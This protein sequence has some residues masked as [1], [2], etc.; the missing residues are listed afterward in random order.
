[1]IWIGK[2]LFEEPPL[3]RSE[4]CRSGYFVP[5]LCPNGQP[6]RYCRQF[7]DRLL[8][9]DLFRRNLQAVLIG[10]R[11]YLNAYNGVATVFEEVIM[12]TDL[13][14]LQ[15]LRPYFDKHLFDWRSRFHVGPSR[16]VRDVGFGQRI[17]VNFTVGRQWQGVK[18]DKAR[19]DHVR[20]QLSAQEQ[21]EFLLRWGPLS[22]NRNVRHEPFLTGRFLACD[23]NAIAYQVMRSE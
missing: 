9:E 20:W 12:D 14:S 7:R 3:N 15:N 10:L 5:L 2:L 6:S 17:T 11:G 16:T 21:A 1:M 18:G 19:R 13:R 23:D 22:I 8:L 4:W